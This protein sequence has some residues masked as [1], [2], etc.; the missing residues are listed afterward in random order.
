LRLRLLHGVFDQQPGRTQCTEGRQVERPSPFSAGHAAEA[1][2][3]GGDRRRANPSRSAAPVPLGRPEAKC[4]STR[5][6]GTRRRESSSHHLSQQACVALEAPFCRALQRSSAAAEETRG[7][8]SG[9]A[10]AVPAGLGGCADPSASEAR[11]EVQTASKSAGLPAPSPRGCR[12]GS[13]QPT[14][15][16]PAWVNDIRTAVAATGGAARNRLTSS[17]EPVLM[18][19]V[20]INNWADP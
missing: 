10:S 19:S 12:T 11:P 4:A 17:P 7:S 15:D 14:P 20:R 6:P 16:P 8:P 2:P 1:D 18:R 5:P 9:P 13:V 3:R